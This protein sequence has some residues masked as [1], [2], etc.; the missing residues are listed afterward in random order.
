MHGAHRIDVVQL[1]LE[2]PFTIAHG[3]SS[4]RETVIIEVDGG[5]GEAATV[6]YMGERTADTV[7]ALKGLLPLLESRT[8]S[9]QDVHAQL[10]NFSPA[11][12]CAADMALFD[13]LGRS[14]EQ[15]LWELVGAPAP[16]PF[17]TSLTSAMDAPDEMAAR[18]REMPAAI[19]KV[20]A[21]GPQDEEAIEAIRGSTNARLRL[22]AN[23][24]WSR[25]RA[26][27]LLPRIKRF[28]IELV[29]QPF[30]PSDD[31][32]LG[33]LKAQGFGIPVFADESVGRLA[34]ISRIAPNVDGIVV[35]LRKLGGVRATVEAIKLAR[36]LGLQVMIGC[37]IESSLAVTAAA[38]LAR[39]CD[40]VDLDA[41]LLIRNDP[42]L[43]VTY[44]GL[45]GHVPSG[46]GI[47]AI[48]RNP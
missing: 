9:I 46:V 16:T 40:L 24:G 22:D 18:V 10:S 45:Q 32:S 25:E 38:H 11:V 13:H 35:K 17:E 1:E 27:V 8:R 21:G 47:G 37:M 44:Q 36:T 4:H 29:E 33:W 43:G 3:S 14:L 26:A 2:R 28:E 42:Y 6:P 23:G 39:M 48:R 41:P 31:V 7:E 20:K 19:Y 15:P 30:S 12:S 5:A 34:D